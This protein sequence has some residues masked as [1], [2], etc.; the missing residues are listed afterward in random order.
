VIDV[1]LSSILSEVEGLKDE[2]AQALMSLIR[3]PAI[4]PEN[5]GEG[6]SKK[7]EKLMQILEEVGFD[8]I[9]RHDA[10]DKRVPSGVRPNII[11]Y[12]GAVQESR[13]WI[14]TH[15]DV[16]PPG[17]DALWTVTPPFE[18]TIK[19]GRVYGRG[20]EDNGQSL[21]ASIFAVKALRNLGIKPK[22]TLT[23]AFVSDE[24][25]G[26]KYGIGHLIDEG[27]FKKEDLMVVPDYGNSEGDFIEIAE[28]SMLWFRTKTRGKQVHA[29]TPAKGLNAHRI[30]MRYALALDKLLHEKYSKRDEAFNPPESTFEPTKKENN[31]EAVN[32]IPGEDTIYFDC[33]VL[34]EYDLHDVLRDA[35]ELAKKV[36][37]ESGAKVKI[38]TM[39]ENRA[40]KQTPVDS[41]VVSV[42]REALEISRRIKP[43]VGGIGAG[44]CA[45][46][47]RK[48]GIPAVC[49]STID[50]TAHQPDEYAKIGNMAA[51]AAVFA[52]LSLC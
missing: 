5:G 45:A 34:P 15:M 9:E 7:A 12:Y 24:E 31:V 21:V 22:R 44:T 14:V 39:L 13:L 23:L 41:K 40:P 47:F 11:A 48:I 49:W 50:E 18:P 8:R 25:Q 36:E 27:L 20:S 32:I 26:N 17:D 38:E 52:L 19:D 16:V 43:E 35:D 2:M 37:T 28:K 42:L 4:A 10:K 1:T 29:S 30:G 3:I 46:F 51:D 33:R 6:E